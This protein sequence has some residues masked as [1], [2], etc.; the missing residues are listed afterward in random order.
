MSGSFG[1]SQGARPIHSPLVIDHA[2]TTCLFSFFRLFIEL[3]TVIV[4]ESRSDGVDSEDNAHECSLALACSQRRSFPSFFGLFP[5][6][7]QSLVLC[8]EASRVEDRKC[9]V[10]SFEIGIDEFIS[11]VPWRVF[12]LIRSWQGSDLAEAER[13]GEVEK[14]R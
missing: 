7:Y 14:I 10:E 9:M 12:D 5:R 3:Q 13:G 11:E 6:L 4:H 2:H 8:H 1:T